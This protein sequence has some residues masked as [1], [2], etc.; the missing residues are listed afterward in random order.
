MCEA[1]GCTPSE[2]LKQ[3]A[4]LVEQIL[5]YRTARRAVELFESDDHKAA[6]KVFQKYPELLE[7]LGLMRRAQEPGATWRDLTVDAAQLRADGEATAR[8]ERA[9]RRQ[10]D[11]EDEEAE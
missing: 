1:F 10:S 4:A 7:T 5:E 9:R 3:D 8:A 6:V 2:A 11:D